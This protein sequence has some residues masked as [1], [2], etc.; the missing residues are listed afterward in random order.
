[1]TFYAAGG[2]WESIKELDKQPVSRVETQREVDGEIM[3]FYAAG[4]RWESIKEL[5]KQP[6][7]RV[8]MWALM[9]VKRDA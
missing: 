9:N 7:S 6:V 2:R 5:D 1:M 8:M 4:G 3:T